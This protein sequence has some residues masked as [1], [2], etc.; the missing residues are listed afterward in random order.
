M[1]GT[2]AQY[3]KRLLQKNMMPQ[4]KLDKGETRREAPL[5][6]ADTPSPEEPSVKMWPLWA[7]LVPTMQR[8]DRLN[9]A[10]VMPPCTRAYFGA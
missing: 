4:K 7:R 2:M 5:E 1:L 8:Q 9:A 3:K 10:A 6:G